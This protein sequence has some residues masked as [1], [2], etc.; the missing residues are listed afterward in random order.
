M[1][2]AKETWICLATDRTNLCR[3][4]KTHTGTLMRLQL[5]AISG[6]CEVPPI[7]RPYLSKNL[8]RMECERVPPGR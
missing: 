7:A 2:G 5:P 6:Y 1:I 4:C 3:R 8:V